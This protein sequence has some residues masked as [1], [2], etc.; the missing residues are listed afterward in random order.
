MSADVVSLLAT[1]DKPAA[2]W[3]V[4][5]AGG[6][7]GSHLVESL[8]GAGQQVVA[9]DNFVTGHRANIDRVLAAVPVAARANFRFVEG[10]V[11]DAAL[12][13]EVTR[14]MDYVLHQAAIGSVPRS[15]KQPLFSF[16]ANV[17]GFFKLL[18]AAKDAGVRKFVYASSSSVYGD[19]PG[20][21]K[22]EDV[23]GNVL[24][25]Y[26]ATKAADELF[27]DVV[28]R[29]YD[30]PCAGLRYFNVFGSRQDPAGPYAAVI[31]VWVAALMA[32]EPVNI[33]GDGET[34]RDFCFVD[35]AVQA[36]L[37]AAITVVPDTPH[38]VY[39]VAVGHQTTLNELFFMLRDRVA[40]VYPQAA[41]A[42]PVYRDFRAGD[43]RHS[44]AD[45]SR[46]R[47]RLGYAPT[48]TVE[49][50]LDVAVSWYLGSPTINHV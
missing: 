9:V 38:E 29:C 26:A 1:L 40:R 28:G 47:D 43:I 27:A 31:P 50:G 7:I 12:M 39:N 25:P 33:N 44:L 35:N 30:M 17:D 15:I 18:I 16:A 4:T 24:S 22:L 3:L 5:G 37:R 49:Q 41:G 6:F 20:L 36:N 32:G 19:A 8:L 21:P 14:G 23:T 10:D 11:C 13:V 46:A 34:S 42:R 48:H 2:R 45:V